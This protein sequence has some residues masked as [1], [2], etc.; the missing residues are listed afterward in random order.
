MAMYIYTPKDYRNKITQKDL[1][2]FSI[3]IGET[4][5]F[6]QADRHLS[7]YTLNVV[8]QYRRE[9]EDYIIK[10]PTF[11]KTLKPYKIKEPAPKIVKDM[12]KYSKIVGVGPMA[13]V[14]GAIA[15]YVGKELLKKSK[16]VIVEN[17]GDIF[18]KT[19][20]NRIVAIYAG[21]SPFSLKI[22]IELPGSDKPIGICTSSGTVGHSLSFGLAD[23]VTVISE[24]CILA[25]ACATAIGNLI[26]KTNGFQKGIKFAKKIK[27]AQGVLIIKGNKLTAFG[28][29]KLTKI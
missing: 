25:D 10:N 19:A 16:E 18:L 23:A 26:N 6:V 28:D 11:Q 9:I 7:R 22:G 20:Q 15:E 2:S 1:I 29:V 5:L 27:D 8:K 3:S 13:S 17:G 21:I 14:A 4:D 12:A 24:S